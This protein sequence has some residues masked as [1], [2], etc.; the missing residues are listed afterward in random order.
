MKIHN[1]IF[2]LILLFAVQV[3]A[4]DS[5]TQHGITWTF[6]ADIAEDTSENYRYG[7]FANDD[8]WII[9]TQADSNVY[10]NTIDPCSIEITSQVTNGGND[11]SCLAAQT[12]EPNSE[13]G[14]GVDWESYWVLGGDGSDGAWQ[15]ATVYLFERTM[16]GSMINPDP[17]N[18]STNGYDSELSNYTIGFNV[19]LDV[20][21]VNP[22]IVPVNS[23][24][25]STISVVERDSSNDPWI[26]TAAILTVLSSAPDADSFRPPYCGT[27]KSIEFNISN[28][29]YNLLG[30]LTPTASVPLLATVEDYF[31]GVWLDHRG[32]WS[33]RFFH[34]ED[35]MPEYGRDM[36]WRI[37]V[38]ALMLHC[39][40][41]NEQ[42]ETLF[43]RFVQLGIDFFGIVED[44]GIG[45]WSPDGGHASG[46][47][48]PILFAGLVLDNNDMK[49]IGV[50]SGVYA[51]DGEYEAGDLPPDYIHFGEDCQ[52]FYVKAAD[53]YTSPYTLRWQNMGSTTGTVSVENGSKIVTC[54]GSNWTS[55]NGEDDYFGVDGDNQ[56]YSTSGRSYEI[57]SIDSGTQLTLVENY[58]GDTAS[59]VNYAV[60]NFVYYGHGN[61]ANKNQHD[62]LTSA[63][64]GRPDFGLR[65]ATIPLWDGDSWDTSYR[66]TATANVWGGF[67]LAAHIMNVKSE[68]NHNALFDYMDRYM[69]Y[70]ADIG[71]T[72]EWYRQWNTFTE[73]MWDTYRAGYGDVWTA[74]GGFIKRFHISRKSGGKQTKSGGK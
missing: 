14:V 59:G 11:Y 48:W 5:L 9:S 22:L 6:D 50:K 2:I 46:R 19:A 51:Y 45:N 3:N 7:T 54:S 47:K 4:L 27:D 44:G 58:S 23:S 66:N 61:T 56:A 60:S 16:N 8:Y 43:I 63:H 72:G 65:H 15:D 18:E 24:L 33:G 37:G 69:Q 67:V 30:T 38:G 10:I 62:E 74:G 70:H 17:E 41:T 57:D 28:L 64:I 34:P 42:K 73:E 40:Y 26:Q 35:S 12:S 29:D 32:E 21:T 55:L 49:E 25:V 31:E 36:S 52:T 53:V 20:N 13:P 71:D 1:L 39:D 68:W